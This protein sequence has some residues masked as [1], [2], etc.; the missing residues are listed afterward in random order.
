MTSNVAATN[1][2]TK[3]PTIEEL[4]KKHVLTVHEAARILD[5]NHKTVRLMIASGDLHAVRVRRNVRIP[6]RAVLSLTKQDRVVPPR[7]SSH[8]G[9]T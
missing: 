6:I 9:E 2:S 1:E 7:S 5:V 3:E 4:L 8:G